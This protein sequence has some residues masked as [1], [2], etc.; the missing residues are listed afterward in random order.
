MN[1]PIR[2][3]VIGCGVIAQVMHLPHL[4][5]PPA[6][7]ELAAVCDIAQPVAAGCAARFGARAAFSDWREM[8]A[9]ELDAVMVLTSGN[10]AP[11]AI[12]AAQAGAHVFVEKPMALSVA[13][14]LAMIEAAE[15]AGV[16]LMVGT[17]KRYDP[18]YERLAE[19]LPEYRGEL[20]LARVTTLESPFEPYVAHYPLLPPAPAEAGMI[21]ELRRADEAT[22]DAVL[23]DADEVTRFGY[24]WLLLDNLVHEFNALR[25]LLG[26]PTEVVYA[27]LARE[28]VSVNLLFGDTPCHLSWVDLLSGIARYRQEFA[29]YAPEQRLILELPSPY[30]RNEPSRL[31]VEGGEV[32]ST[33]SWIREEVVSYDEAFRRELD[34]FADCIATGRAARTSG[35]DGLADLRLCESI[36][37]VHLG[38]EARLL[39]VG[40]G[41]GT[42]AV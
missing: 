39:P 8:L 2:V 26:E 34:E 38:L 10:H 36:A 14:G 12:A 6:A 24:R 5:Q 11:I 16:C 41:D 19:L 33:H 18:A 7:F 37:R 28:T 40:A 32:G 21:E 15:K 23:G 30:L 25:G 9:S 4:S 27:N 42:A 1:A 13:D 35:Y 17:M 20:R 31:I 22:V 29:F 3:G